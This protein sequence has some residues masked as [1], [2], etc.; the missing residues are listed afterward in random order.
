MNKQQIFNKVAEHLLTQMA[1]SE[2]EF[3]CLYRG[4]NGLKCAVG[5]L[6]PDDL[7]EVELEN[8]DVYSLFD[9][10]GPEGRKRIGIT[11]YRTLDFLA[12]LQCIHDSFPPDSWRAELRVLANKH[13]L[14][15]QVLERF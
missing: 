14:N 1:V 13:R 10:L 15:R 3:G 5:I 8:S 11:R 6:I 2:D 12:D 9:C 7:F 4:P